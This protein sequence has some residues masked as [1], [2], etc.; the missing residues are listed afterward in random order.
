MFALGRVDD[1]K[2]RA[3]KKKHPSVIL[4]KY[5]TYS[6]SDVSAYSLIA[7]PLYRIQLFISTTL[8]VFGEKKT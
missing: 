6:A 1:K 5:R 4:S 7:R 8:F 2:K 3:I